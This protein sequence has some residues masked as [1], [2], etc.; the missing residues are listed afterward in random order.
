MPRAGGDGVQRL[1]QGG[2]NGPLAQGDHGG[3]HQGLLATVR[4]GDGAGR[5]GYR[6]AAAISVVCQVGEVGRRQGE[7]P[8]L[9]L[10]DLGAEWF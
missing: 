4:S 3:Y 2:A 9:H 6:V 10:G 8:A 1:G 5:L 7:V